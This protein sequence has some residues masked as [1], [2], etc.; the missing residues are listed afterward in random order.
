MICLYRDSRLV[1]L[2]CKLRHVPSCAEGTPI[3]LLC[4]CVLCSQARF[5]LQG[6]SGSQAYL[7]PFASLNLE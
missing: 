1:T 2:A 6:M 4:S 3:L 5:S 7:L